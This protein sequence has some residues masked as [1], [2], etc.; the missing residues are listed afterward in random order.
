MNKLKRKSKTIKYNVA[1]G[2]ISS[3][4]LIVFAENQQ[5]IQEYIPA[6]AYLIVIMI[7]SGVGVYLRTIT[8]EPVEPMRKKHD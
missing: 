4:M 6:W 7:N 1:W 3:S 2:L 8:T 5:L